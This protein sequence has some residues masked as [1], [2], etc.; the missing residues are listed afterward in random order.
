MHKI[1]VVEDDEV[2]NGGIQHC[3]NDE[4]F[5]V[6]GVYT[7][8]QALTV[9]QSEKYDLIILDINLPDK[10][11]F[12]LCQEIR[13]IYSSI[14]I[15]FLTAR[16]LEK[17]VMKGFDLGADDYITK[18]FRIN[19]LKKKIGAILKR[20][21]IIQDDFYEAKYLKIDLNKREVFQS[22][23]LINLTP[24]EFKI[25]EL[26]IKEKSKVITKENFIEY[27]YNNDGDFIDE[28]ALSVYI[29][30]LRGKIEEPD[31]PFIKTI[32]GMGYMWIEE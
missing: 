13:K 1:L 25:L 18:P 24:T 30:R 17:D 14:P 29:S 21:K 20:Y 26:F 7:Y 4:K 15:I 9:I 22:G 11:G 3:L 5:S 32:Y 16:D 27:L 8:Q 19:I 28:H 2:L 12:F 6:E 23:R 31:N 10:D